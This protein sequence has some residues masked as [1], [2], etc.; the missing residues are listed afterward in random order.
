MIPAVVR[1]EAVPQRD[2]TAKYMTNLTTPRHTLTTPT[3]TYHP[4]TYTYNPKTY[5]DSPDIHI[6]PKDTHIQHNP[7]T[8]TYNTHK[9]PNVEMF[10]IFKPSLD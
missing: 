6:P 3:Y 9:T 7:K 2:N 4:Q 5:T 10:A 1:V 8:Y